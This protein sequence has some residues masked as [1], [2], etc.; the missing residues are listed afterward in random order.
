[1]RHPIGASTFLW[2]SLGACTTLHAELPPQSI[3]GETLSADVLHNDAL[4][5][6]SQQDLLADVFSV[7]ASD[8]AADLT[9]QLQ[10][11]G[12]ESDEP[13][14]SEQLQDN[15]PLE[16]RGQ[17]VFFQEN[18][19]SSGR[20]RGTAL[21]PMG[22]ALLLGA[23]AD[24]L[25]GE[26]FTDDSDLSLKLN[27]LYV[28][29]APKPMPELRFVAGLIDLTSYFDRNSFSKDKTTHFFNPVFETSP[30]LNA[31]GIGAKPGL[32]I[33][34]SPV[35]AVELKASGFSSSREIDDWSL[36]AFAGELGVRWENVIVRGTYTTARDAGNR[37]GFD[38][39]F[40]FDRG[41]GRFGLRD[42]D[43]EEAY[44][45]NGEVFIPAA[46][47]GLF[48][49]Y[50]RYRNIELDEAGDTYSFGL[51]WLDVAWEGDRLGLGYGRELSQ[52]DLR[53]GNRPDVLEA[54]YDVPISDDARVAVSLQEREEFTETV[55]GVRIRAQF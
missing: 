44:G 23:E 28:A 22:D 42:G 20:L 50:S 33:N 12:S 2:V 6:V 10:A 34:W 43:R 9:S 1:M 4:A 32:L 27:E 14:R 51:N 21:Y 8:L 48:G 24:L 26:A 53:T 38:E 30:A 17:A 39:I 41:D 3:S 45:V 47:L 19:E 40:R 15:G 55:L 5:N 35:D 46:N 37:S 13:L 31:A 7:S 16:L 29:Y 49:R 18:D 54:F 52:D 11:N 25:F 36:D